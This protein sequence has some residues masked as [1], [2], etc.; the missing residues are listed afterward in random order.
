MH[1]QLPPG[2]MAAQLGIAPVELLLRSKGYFQF[3]EPV[4]V[5][6]R[7]KKTCDMPLALDTQLDPEFGGVVIY[8][9]RPDGRITEYK[10]VMCKLAEPSVGE[11]TPEDQGVKGED[12]HSQNIFLSYG[13]GGFYFDEPGEYL[14]RAFYQGLG[15]ALIASNL[16]RIVIGRPFSR[17]EERDAQ[18]VFSYETGVALYLNGSSSSFLETG[19]DQIRGLADR[20]KESPV[21]AHAAFVLARNLARPFYP[22]KDN[23]RVEARAAEPDEALAL[24][25]P[26][27]QQ[28]KRD[29]TTF[30][31]LVYHELRRTRADLMVAMGEKP[32]AKKELRALARELKKGGVNQPVLDEIRA[33]AADL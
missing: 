18:D 15:D 28:Q 3:L 7:I 6:L 25:E 13:S 20:Y 29:D 16:H 30:T 5:E 1:E 9:R 26:A 2:A 8:I 11:L 17:E 12:R 21:G 31:N 32:E 19:M 10:P 27:I 23:A 22:I 33:Y 4:F 14:V 24:T